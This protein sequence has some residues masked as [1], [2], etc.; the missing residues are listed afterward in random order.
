MP[1]GPFMHQGPCSIRGYELV[2]TP[3]S[4]ETVCASSLGQ[5]AAASGTVGFIHIMQQSSFLF[6]LGIGCLRHLKPGLQV[7][8]LTSTCLLYH[9]RMG[10]LLVLG[11]CSL[12]QLLHAGLPTT[13]WI[14]WWVGGWLDPLL[15]LQGGWGHGWCLRAAGVWLLP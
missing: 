8:L 15:S 6:K 4:V 2:R 11:A 1:A 9:L 14:A 7:V 13:A 5:P 3:P 10:L 12:M